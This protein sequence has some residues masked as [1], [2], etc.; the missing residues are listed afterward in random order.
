MVTEFRSVLKPWSLRGRIIG[1]ALCTQWRIAMTRFA[2]SLL[3]WA[4]GL[5]GSGYA[6]G[7]MTWKSTRSTVSLATECADR[8]QP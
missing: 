6:G 7:T 5:T 3:C 4:L 1:S 2:L 8:R